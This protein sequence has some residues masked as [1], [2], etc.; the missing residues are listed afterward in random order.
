MQRFFSSRV[1]GA[2]CFLLL[3]LNLWALAQ[4]PAKPM[5]DLSSFRAIAADTLGIVNSGNLSRAKARIKDLETSWDRAE[6]RLRPRNPERLRTIDKAI[7]AALAQLRADRPQ[8]SAAKDALENLLASLDR[9]DQTVGAAPVEAAELSVTDIIA[10]AEKLQAG[11]SVLDVSF[12]P[13]DGKPIYAVRTYA[14][15]KVWDGLLDG[16][17]GAAIGQGTVIDESALDAEDKV[18]VAALKGAKITLG[19]AI[20]SAEKISRALSAG[21]EQVRG[22]AVWEILIAGT[23]AQPQQI[24]IDP[25]TGKI[26]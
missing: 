20:A 2:L 23:V 17:S 26:L 21:L 10:A 8:A 6:A 13:Q 11:A 5:G 3:G 7:D 18:E 25:I 12:E 22:R 16:S 19:Q 15:G 9:S 14:N 1:L 4:G 24:H